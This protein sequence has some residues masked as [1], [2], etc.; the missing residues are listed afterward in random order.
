MKRIAFV[1][2]HD[3]MTHENEN[4]QE[5][6]DEDENQAKWIKI[7]VIEKGK[8]NQSIEFGKQCL[9]QSYKFIDNSKLRNKNT[10]RMFVASTEFNGKG[11][12]NK[13]RRE[14]KTRKE[15]EHIHTQRKFLRFRKS[16]MT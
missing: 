13:K 4:E 8:K 14:R 9:S 15:T 3:G 11:E 6:D 7:F 5:E 1:S 16:K 2:K 10:C 12:E